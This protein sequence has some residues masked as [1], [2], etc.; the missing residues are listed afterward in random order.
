MG[1]PPWDL[2]DAAFSPDGQRLITAGRD[3]WAEIWEVSSGRNVARVRPPGAVSE[4]VRI[5]GVAYS[6]DGQRVATA[7]SSI[8]DFFSPQIWDASS[9]RAMVDL[10]RHTADVNSV[11]FSR[12]GQ[13]VVTASSDGTARISDSATGYSLAELLGDG[14]PLTSAAFSPDGARI[15]IANGPVARVYACDTCLPTDALLAL[16]RKSLPSP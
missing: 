4:M 13:R 7:V 3:G 2:Y 11:A 6:P 10:V 15:I 9:G 8:Y 12:D 16:A 5:L 14:G 1:S